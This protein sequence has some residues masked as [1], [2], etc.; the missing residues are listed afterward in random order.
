MTKR[1]NKSNDNDTTNAELIFLTTFYI[2]SQG[3]T[4]S[5]KTK[6]TTKATTKT[7]KADIVPMPITDLK[8]SD[9]KSASLSITALSTHMSVLQI[10]KRSGVN[11]VTL[12]NIQQGNQTR[13]TEKVAMRLQD[14]YQ[15]LDLNDLK[16]AQYNAP[17]DG[18]APP[19]KRGRK[20]KT[21]KTTTNVPTSLDDVNER[22]ESLEIELSALKEYRTNVEKSMKVLTRSLAKV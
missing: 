8:F 14:W 18:D 20:A 10:S 16:S 4:M 5:T 1:F 11:Y 15:S 2:Y 12:R 21:A 19:R 17:A 22:I 7:A 13:M 3:V 9:V 6:A